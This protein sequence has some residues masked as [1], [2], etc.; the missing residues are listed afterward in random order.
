[1]EQIE[2]RIE[3]LDPK[4]SVVLVCQGGQRAAV[5]KEAGLRLGG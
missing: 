1:M 4:A 3:D 2:A 5:C